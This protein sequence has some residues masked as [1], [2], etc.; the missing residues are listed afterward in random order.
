MSFF[1]AA[2]MGWV[3]PLPLGIAMPYGACRSWRPRSRT[4][5]WTA[6]PHRPRRGNRPAR[7]QP[8]RWTVPDSHR[9]GLVVRGVELV[10]RVAGVGGHRD[11]ALALDRGR[12]GDRRV[13]R[14]ARHRALGGRRAR[15]AAAAP[16][17]RE[18]ERESGGGDDRYLL[19]VA[20][21]VPMLVRD[22]T[23][24]SFAGEGGKS[25]DDAPRYMLPTA[26]VAHVTTE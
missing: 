26:D 17:G 4:G 24:E 2:R 18:C 22:A 8:A 10:G 20:L 15:T 19:L 13:S 23:A 7:H 25:A 11:R 5:P 16:A 1:N 12:N 21:F 3:S 9:S 6:W 14:S